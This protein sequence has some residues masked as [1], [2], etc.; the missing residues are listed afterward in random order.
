[1]TGRIEQGNK[2]R[3]GKGAANKCRE[4]QV[5]EVKEMNSGDGREM[6]ED[7]LMQRMGGRRKQGN[8]CRLH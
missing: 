6:G 4:G 8:E 5:E 1:M 7:E 2:C 3:G